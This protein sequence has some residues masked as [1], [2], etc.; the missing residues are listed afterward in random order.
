MNFILQP[1]HIMLL[2]LSAMIDGERDKAI[3]YLL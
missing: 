2:A 1:W 3:A